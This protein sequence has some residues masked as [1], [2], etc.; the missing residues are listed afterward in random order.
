MNWW[1]RIILR[2]TLNTKGVSKMF[3]AIRDALSGKK[4]YIVC[5]GLI[6]Q[7]VIEFIADENAGKLINKILLALGGM[8]LRAGISKDK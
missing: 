3:G 5:L 1:Q 7:A 2:F 6:V 8:S 4:T